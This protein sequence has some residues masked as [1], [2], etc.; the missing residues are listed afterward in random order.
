[1]QVEEI[2]KREE[3][4]HKPFVTSITK[5]RS[6][7]VCVSSTHT[8]THMYR[9]TEPFLP[10]ALDHGQASFSRGDALSSRGV[11]MK[12]QQNIKECPRIHC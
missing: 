8:N 3:Q 12:E 7:K 9:Q 2:T 10:T 6:K 4:E 11:H 5:Y 1:M